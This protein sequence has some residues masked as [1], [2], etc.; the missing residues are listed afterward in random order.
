VRSILSFSFVLVVIMDKNSKTAAGGGRRTTIVTISERAGV[1][2]STVTRALRGD[3]RISQATRDRIAAL[4]KDMGYTANALARTLS[5]GKS[6]LFGLVLGSAENPFYTE[7]FHEAARQAEI[8]GCRLLIIHAGGG[9]IEEKTAEALLQYQVDG[10]IISSAV[11]SSRAAEIC[12]TNRV[13]LVMVN[14]VA[15]S[16]GCVVTCD[17]AGGG[18]EIA[19]HL[20]NSGR[21]RFAIVNTSSSSSTG[22]ER[23][24]GFRKALANSTA[25]VVATFDG[26]SNYQG[27][28]VAGEQIARLA[29]KDRPDAVFAVSDIM[30]TGVLDA[31][32]LNDIDVP[33]D[34]AVA[35][36][37]DLAIAARQIYSLTTFKQPLALM[38]ERAFDMLQARVRDGTM[39]DEFVTLRGQLVARNSTTTAASAAQQSGT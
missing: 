3:K 8:R 1:S 5:S 19:A 12:A 37:D 15:L 10:C 24:E 21:R 9:P 6:G 32:R 14:R 26:H 17:N 28:F 27:G 16:H 25:E 20:L 11:L 23:T 22:V 36:F 13:P 39:P 7:L 33:G 38:I 4:A 31:F 29:A 34:I 18:G 35:G 2:H 30:A